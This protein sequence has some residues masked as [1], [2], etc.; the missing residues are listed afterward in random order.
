MRASEQSRSSASVRSSRLTRGGVLGVFRQGSTA[1]ISV[2]AGSSETSRRRGVWPFG[3]G[4]GGP[5]GSPR[6]SQGGL[7]EASEGAPNSLDRGAE[8]TP[9]VSSLAGGPSSVDATH[10]PGDRVSSSS[11][12]SSHTPPPP[13]ITSSTF[14]RRSTGNITAA[15]GIRA[16]R[17]SGKLSG[18]GGADGGGGGGPS[19]SP[20]VQ[21]GVAGSNSSKGRRKAPRHDSG[22]QVA[23]SS[24]RDTSS[25]ASK[26]GGFFQRGGQ[27]QAS[28][29]DDR[30]SAMQPYGSGNVGA[31]GG[32]AKKW[33]R[34]ESSVGGRGATRASA[35]PGGG[36][37]LYTI[38]DRAGQAGGGGDGSSAGR[39]RKGQRANIL[40]QALLDSRPNTGPTPEMAPTAAMAALGAHADLTALATSSAARAS[41]GQYSGELEQ[42]EKELDHALFN[43]FAFVPI[44]VVSRMVKGLDDD[45]DGP[46]PRPTGAYDSEI[47]VAVLF[48][49]VSGFTQLT[50]RLQREKGGEEGAELL[51]GILNDFFEQL[52][53]IVHEHDGDVIKFAGDAVLSMWSSTCGETLGE[54]VC[55][56]SAC[57]LEQLAR[58]DHYQGGFDTTLRLHLGLGAGTATGMDVG[59]RHRREFVV[60]GPPLEE[61]SSAEGAAGHGEVV[62]G[63][64]VWQ[65][66]VAADAKPSV[67]PV[68]D[69][70]KAKEAGDGFMVLKALGNFDPK[71]PGVSG[72]PRGQ[73]VQ[74][75]QEALL[76]KRSDQ[77]LDELQRYTAGPVRHH[78][79]ASSLQYSTEFREVTMLFVRLTN[80]NF[81]AGDA[82]DKLQGAVLIIMASVQR[83]EGTITRISIDDKGTVLKVTFGL[84]PYLHTDDPTRGVLC[85]MSIRDAVRTLRLKACIGIT[86]GHV[87]VGCVGAE[88]RCEYT[89]YGD[90][91]NMAARYM[92]NAVNEVF[93]DEETYAK[94]AHTVDW[95]F[96]KPIKV[97]GK[98]EPVPVF[99]PFAQ[100]QGADLE[101][102]LAERRELAGGSAKAGAED[103]RRTEFVGRLAEMHSITEVLNGVMNT[104]LEEQPADE[105]AATQAAG[106][107]FGGTP[108]A[109]VR[110]RVIAVTGEAGIGKSR[111]VDE[112]CR[113]VIAIRPEAVIL[114]TRGSSTESSSL[115]YPWAAVF[116]KVL[117]DYEPLPDGRRSGAAAELAQRA[118]L[119]RMLPDEYQDHAHLLNP[120]LGLNLSQNTA[121]LALG[122][123]VKAEIVTAM[124]VHM[125][126]LGAHRA[127]TVLVMEDAQHLDSASWKLLQAVVSRVLDSMEPPGEADEDEDQ[128]RFPLGFAVVITCQTVSGLGLPPDMVQMV[129][130]PTAL[131][132]TLGHMTP[133]ELVRIARNQLGARSLSEKAAALLGTKSAGSPFFCL[134]LVKLLREQGL[135]QVE[136][137]VVSIKEGKDGKGIAI[138][139]SVEQAI[140]SRVDRLGRKYLMALKCASVAGNDFVDEMLMVMLPEVG[141]S[142]RDVPSIVEELCG[143]GLLEHC[144]NSKFYTHSFKSALVGDVV[145]ERL[146]FNQRRELHAAVAA[147]I[148]GRFAA[149]LSNFYPVL[150]QHW[151][152]AA[153]DGEAVRYYQ[154]CASVAFNNY[155]NHE[156]VYFLNEVLKIVHACTLE[157]RAELRIGAERHAELAA[158][159]AD[160]S[161]RIGMVAQAMEAV[162]LLMDIMDMP[163]PAGSANRKRALLSLEVAWSTLPLAARAHV[164]RAVRHAPPTNRALEI[165]AFGYQMAARGY[166]L[167]GDLVSHDIVALKGLDVAARVGG[168]QRCRS[169]AAAALALGRVGRI[170]MA[171]ALQRDALRQ[172]ELVPEE[173]E[174]EQNN[175]GQTR[176]YCTMMMGMLLSAELCAWEEASGFFEQTMEASLDLGMWR[177]YEESANQKALVLQAKGSLDEAEALLAK[178]ARSAEGRKDVQ[179]YATLM[180]LR[181]GVLLMLGRH[182]QALPASQELER[183][184]SRLAA[185]GSAPL[186]ISLHGNVALAR[187]QCSDDLDGAEAAA[188]DAIRRIEEIKVPS[189]LALYFAY[190]SVAHVMVEVFTRRPSA[191]S[192]RKAATAVGYLEVF[193]QRFAAAGPRFM[194]YRGALAWQLR[195]SAEARKTWRDALRLAKR[196]NL[197]YEHARIRYEVALRTEAEEEEHLAMGELAA[198][199][200][201]V[202]DQGFGG[203]GLGAPAAGNKRIARG[204]IA[205]A[206]PSR[207]G[208]LRGAASPTSSA[209]PRQGLARGRARTLRPG[210]DLSPAD[211]KFTADLP[212]QA[213]RLDRFD[214][215]A[216]T[217]GLDW[218]KGGGV[219]ARRNKDR[220]DQEDEEAA[221]NVEAGLLSGL[222]HMGQRALGAGGGRRKNGGGGLF[223]S[224]IFASAGGAQAAGGAP[225]LGARAGPGGKGSAQAPSRFASATGEPLS[226][227]QKGDAQGAQVQR[228]QLY[229]PSSLEVEDVA[230]EGDAPP[231]AGGAGAAGGA[232]P[233]WNANQSLG[234]D[235]DPAELRHRSAQYTAE[236]ASH[237]KEGLLEEED[238]APA[239]PGPPADASRTPVNEF[240]VPD[241]S[242]TPVNESTVVDLS[243]GRSFRDS[244]DSDH[245]REAIIEPADS[246]SGNFAD[247]LPLWPGVPMAADTASGSRAQET[248][249]TAEGAP[250]A[251]LGPI[252]EH[253]DAARESTVSGVSSINASRTPPAFN[254]PL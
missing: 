123:D 239:A 100:L 209:R 18:G 71:A 246:A 78:I 4:G 150:A 151:Q 141:I 108:T 140:I 31:G 160:A 188:A 221:G 86:T 154:L 167:L 69:P 165:T 75:M 203:L 185:T 55:R 22:G 179:M 235:A 19:A 61:M 189:Q 184:E 84:P 152:Q 46:V 63:P 213:D 249:S 215:E 180:C 88:H 138:P 220:R 181:V 39:F 67:V 66:L 205:T 10:H 119:M 216:T 178:A 149:E 30:Q 129:K 72:I 172:C 155:A 5:A 12:Q 158:H 56:A 96:L 223:A 253:P 131:H 247:R 139:D 136:N 166:Y 89:E 7:S 161:L 109:G 53:N 227:Q 128:I 98:E 83:Y 2:A 77:L 242:R 59:T 112:V 137:G 226:R 52:I 21:A 146:P 80:I 157:E 116:R 6:R 224:G 118:R 251:P 33:S 9:L 145:Y 47:E 175:R 76:E 134:E 240:A 243:N 105:F 202:S 94:C 211:G 126:A 36:A 201:D 148:E 99:R 231:G 79:R 142:E 147:W 169:M 248:R 28:F 252:D 25:T 193:A 174:E 171:R 90:K 218:A 199:G 68:A 121:T 222:V 35:R 143:M 237:I 217:G 114:M 60:A 95:D 232:P 200:V 13:E 144:S 93:T 111:L 133:P 207:E 195:R 219:A 91:V 26:G 214:V 81:K 73:W 120:V 50:E 162:E 54:L 204:K 107:Y 43:C 92:S 250:V 74:R 238:L 192:Q 245:A 51:N 176:L 198:L 163:L 82:V 254:R 132:V 29:A 57:A 27:S 229:K 210:V 16:P 42:R 244:I 70:V 170:S 115:L 104:S 44:E 48:S 168:A 1:S 8:H 233:L 135:L 113:R 230:E 177:R 212:P 234:V 34:A 196:L 206:A 85:A 38:V 191:E 159:L 197:R 117:D 32:V 122:D 153:L 194:L 110:K 15:L 23:S 62:V 87:F 49:D 130:M 58:L 103:H 125:L 124:L 102:A 11:A 183:L 156:A 186:L 190:T 65:H 164:P 14:S 20:W 45:P 97:K 41:D 24:D 236:W 225:G 64:T 37:A 127:A 3:I 208:S 187:L 182:A 173:A 40:R 101:A 228:R 17:L 241:A 106:G